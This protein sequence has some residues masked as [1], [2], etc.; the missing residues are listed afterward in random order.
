MPDTDNTS[1][2][3]R[4]V[5]ENRKIMEERKEKNQDAALTKIRTPKTRGR[6]QN[7]GKQD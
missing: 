4:S 6:S 3:H 2:E 1:I 7:N 5:L